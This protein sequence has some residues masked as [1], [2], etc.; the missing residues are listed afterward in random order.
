MKFKLKLLSL[1]NKVFKLKERIVYL[2]KVNPLQNIGQNWDDLEI[3][4]I[5]YMHPHQQIDSVDELILMK[6][7]IHLYL[8]S[9]YLGA[10]IRWKKNLF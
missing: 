8:P 7:N 2:Q 4:Y 6:L 3:I 5:P 10:P 1:D 9:A